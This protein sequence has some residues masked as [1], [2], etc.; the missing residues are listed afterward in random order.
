MTFQEAETL[1]FAGKRLTNRNLKKKG[2]FIFARPSDVLDLDFVHRI[3]SLPESVKNFLA[4]E[5]KVSHSKII[6][7]EYLC[8][9]DGDGTIYNGWEPTESD[10]VSITWEVLK[11]E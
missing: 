4:D 5:R 6:F 3:K 11:D 1:A 10:K 9:W 2:Q 8:M 7:T